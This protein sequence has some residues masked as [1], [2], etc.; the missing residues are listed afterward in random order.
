MIPLPGLISKPVIIGLAAST[1]AA[2]AWG[3][4]QTYRLGHAQDALQHEQDAHKLDIAIWRQG[5]IQATATALQSARNIEQKQQKATQDAEQTT[6][7]LRSRY[8]QLVG[9]WRAS[10]A[11]HDSAGKANLPYDVGSL[12]VSSGTGATSVVPTSDLYIC[13]DAIAKAEGWQDLY[14]KQHAIDRVAE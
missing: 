10:R 4:V 2:G 6:R 3:G 12:S 5:G 11:D 1:L 13:A 8:A 7:D 14:R 9:L